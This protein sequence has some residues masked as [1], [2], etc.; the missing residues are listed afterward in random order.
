MSTD[1]SLGWVGTLQLCQ[2]SVSAAGRDSA[3]PRVTLFLRV[4]RRGCPPGLFAVLLYR[5]PF[6]YRSSPSSPSCQRAQ[7]CGRRLFF[8]RALPSFEGSPGV[9]RASPLLG[10][11]GAGR[12][13]RGRETAQAVLVLVLIAMAG[14]AKLFFFLLPSS[15]HSCLFLN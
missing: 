7:P 9:G 10:G 13:P 3:S 4:A 15:Q 1:V 2:G 6:P 11:F 8:P 14:M 5:G 12:V